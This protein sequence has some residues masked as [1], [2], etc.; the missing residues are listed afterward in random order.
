MD[1]VPWI[2]RHGVVVQTPGIHLSQSETD[3]VLY[4]QKNHKRGMAK[5]FHL[6]DFQR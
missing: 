1:V 4:A 5:G 3:D 6:I 2:F